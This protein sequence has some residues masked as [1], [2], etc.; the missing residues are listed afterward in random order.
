VSAITKQI[1]VRRYSGC[2]AFFLLEFD[3]A[4]GLLPK[5]RFKV[6][7]F[8]GARPAS[9]RAGLDVSPAVRDYLGL[10]STDTTD[11]RFCE[12]REVR[13][14]PWTMRADKSQLALLKGSQ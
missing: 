2:A 11:W 12:A 14:G 10:D 1:R 7:V 6:L 13:P 5:E 8:G 4:P 3:P 9:P